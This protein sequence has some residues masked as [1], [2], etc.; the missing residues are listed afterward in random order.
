MAIQRVACLYRVST[1]GQVDKNDIPM[2]KIECHKFIEN[3]ESWALVQEYYE[4]GVSGYKKTAEQRDILQ[5]IKRDALEG[6]FDILLVFMFDRLGRRDDETPFVVEWFSKQGIEV[7][8]T[9]EGQ[10]EFNHHVD[11]LINYIRFWQSSGESEKTSIRV[12][13]KH[14]QMATEGLF[15][16]GSAPYGY[17]I[18][19]SGVYN[20]KGKELGKLTINDE[21]SVI[22]KEI[23]NYVYLY[24]YGKTKIAKLLNEKNISSSTGGQWNAGV[25]GYILKNPIY[26]GY[27][28]YR[29]RTVKSGTAHNLSSEEWVLSENQIIE[30]QI[31]EEYIWN[32]VQD[33]RLKNSIPLE[34]NTGKTTHSPLFFVGL[35]K[36]GHCGSPLT[37]TYSYKYNSDRT[38]KYVKPKYRCSGKANR[39]KECNGKITYSAE[40]IEDT[41]I[42]EI[43]IVFKKILK[44]RSYKSSNDNLKLY[45]K[46]LSV[47]LKKYNQ[48][49]K[50]HN[51]LIQEISKSLMGES[52]FDSKTLSTLIEQKEKELKTTKT[53]IE[54]LKF[55][56]QRIATTN[57]DNEAIESILGDFI[58]YC[59]KTPHEILKPQIR[60]LINSIVVYR[61]LIDTDL[62]LNKDNFFRIY[63]EYKKDNPD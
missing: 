61:D 11:K 37:T 30:L 55:E 25:V 10:Q 23:F 5:Q 9:Q 34:Y 4:K 20:K 12:D 33:I 48:I 63:S 44:E 54:E 27:P 62:N 1:K 57:Y 50:E 16:G 58:G 49:E 39:S 47:Y 32:K 13:T 22:I 41:V 51:V 59:N 60:L 24:N 21:Q 52:H 40:K 17:N 43:D 46:D 53:K 38:K 31:I 18:T 36:C 35:I 14:E 45:E 42:Q 29:K 7:W 2:Q 28:A 8:S 15:R 19:P 56:I 3:H 26:K 6:K